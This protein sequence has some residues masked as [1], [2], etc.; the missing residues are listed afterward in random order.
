MRNKKPLPVLENITLYDIGH[1]GISVGK[2]DE[3]I[4][5]VGGAVPG[6]VVNVQ[7]T[8]KKELLRSESP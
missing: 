3:I 7:V 1:D 5:F 6:D 2:H 4:V 8:K